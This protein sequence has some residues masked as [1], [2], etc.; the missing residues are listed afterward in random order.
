LGW[1]CGGAVSVVLALERA[2]GPDGTL[3]MPTHSG[4]LSE[5]SRWKNPPVPETWWEV[6]RK[7]M[8][9]Y[10]VDMT[11]TRGVGAI[12]ECF[13]KQKGTLRSAH[14]SVSFAARGP[15]AAFLTQ[16]ESLDFPMGDRSIL[17]RLYDLDAQ[18][19]LLGADFQCATSLHLSEYRARCPGRRLIKCGAPV[20]VNG[21]RQWA[22]Y[23]D[24]ECDDSD[25][26]LIGASFSEGVGRVRSGRV[27]SGTAALM[28]HRALVDYATKWMESNRK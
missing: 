14:P 8:P 6:I 19:L 20:L 26:K 22:E 5:P 2:L 4:D 17:A 21:T 12:A 9:A 23:D 16:G 3:V 7:E 18:I 10:D 25:F 15:K 24:I 13:R 1:V 11:P 27:A 28:S